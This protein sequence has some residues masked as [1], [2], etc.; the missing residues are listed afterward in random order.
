MCTPRAAADV[1]VA[2][3]V[4][5]FRVGGIRYKAAASFADYHLYEEVVMMSASEIERLRNALKRREVLV[6][7]TVR[8]YQLC[9]VTAH[10]YCLSLHVQSLHLLFCVG[11]FHFA[12]NSCSCMYVFHLFFYTACCMTACT[13]IRFVWVFHVHVPFFRPFII[14][15]IYRL[16]QVVPSRPCIPVA[17]SLTFVPFRYR[18]A[19]NFRGIK[20][21]LTSW[22]KKK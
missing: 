6:R 13:C 5:E 2:W 16:P 20:L 9:V 15:L 18:I 4:S 22:S 10:C 11:N 21:P 19:G 17:H 8:H 3:V 14:M 7:K 1:S 12:G